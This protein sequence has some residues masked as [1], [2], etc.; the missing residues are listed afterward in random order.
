M[1]KALI[2]TVPFGD[3]NRLPLELLENAGIDYLINPLNKKLT[4]DQ[5]A[6]MVADFDVIIA[7]TELITE[8]VMARAPKLKLISRVGVGLDGVDLMA[9]KKRGIRVAYTPDAPAPAVAELTLG[10]MLTLLRSVHVSNAQMHEGKWQRIFGRRL[11]EITVGIIG[12][13]RIGT[14]VLRRTKAFGTP[15]I[16]VNDTMPN[17][18]LNREFKLDWVTKEQIYKEADLISLHLPLTRLTKNMIRREQLLSM[19]PDAIIINTAR[20]GIINEGD[21]HDVMMAGHLSG[22]A[23]DVFEHEPYAG[24]LSQIERCL[25]T[26]HMGSMSVDC[27]TRM[28]IEATEEAVRFLSGKPLTSEVPQAE[29]DVQSQGL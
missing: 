10:M 25:L 3:K 12:V 4:E 13:G 15:R 11:A 22:A 9:A 18:E 17:Y 29:Y 6:D 14:R 27:R 21:L 19:K 28:E 2:T 7:G 24:P 20:G 5:L 8:K 23:I 16:L 26:A 1:A